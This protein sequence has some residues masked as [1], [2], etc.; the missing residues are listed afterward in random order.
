M[1]FRA[2]AATAAITLIL[3]AVGQV[4][5][6]TGAARHSILLCGRAQNRVQAETANMIA[7]RRQFLT[8]QLVAA[9]LAALAGTDGIA[10][11]SA[12]PA[13]TDEFTVEFDSSK[14]LGLKL[15]D[16]RVGFQ[17]GTVE[18]TSRVLVAD[19]VPG[20]QAEA[21]GKV[22]IDNVV[23]AV[24][25]INV[26]RETAK[27]VTMR[28]ASAKAEGRPTR[29][30]FKDAL[31]FNERLSSDP[32]AVGADANA[33]VS[34]TIAPQ[35]DAQPAQVL[36]VRRL[37]VPERC[38]RNAQN[39]DLVEIRY[40]GRLED[41]TVFD[42]MELAARFA[43]DSIQFVL[44]KQPAGQFPPSWDVGLVG[45]CV[46]ER[47]ELDVP[48]VLGFGPKGLPKRGVP[49]NARLLYDVECAPATFE[50]HGSP[51]IAPK[52]TAHMSSCAP[53]PEH[54]SALI[55]S[56]PSLLSLSSEVHWCDRTCRLLAINADARI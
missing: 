41:G 27:Q 35:T 38:L 22:S 45:M 42:G 26:E 51:C 49:P 40:V 32:T 52:D 17:Y 3:V 13:P 44:G 16:L 46:G 19:V 7:D 36:S 34:T 33:P 9:S 11:A 56:C 30:T 43:D 48:P 29:I 1:P 18:G 6:F 10:R 53:D 21:T 14:P 31:A 5:G 24:E 23:V 54:P 25:G 37:E 8:N 2:C 39:G 20:G 47:R 50:P 55:P 15:K 4:D 28:L 12:S